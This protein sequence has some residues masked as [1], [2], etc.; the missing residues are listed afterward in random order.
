MRVCRPN[1][2]KRKKKFKIRAMQSRA[3]FRPWRKKSVCWRRRNNLKSKCT[4]LSERSRSSCRRRRLLTSRRSSSRDWLLS[5]LK[6]HQSSLRQRSAPLANYL[7]AEVARTVV[8]QTRASRPIS[9]TR[10][11]AFTTRCWGALTQRWWFPRPCELKMRSELLRR[12]RRK[13]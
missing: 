6:T 11:R 7:I 9:T 12:Q 3:A 1:L 4:R 10:I 13:S 8:T 2:R 5:A